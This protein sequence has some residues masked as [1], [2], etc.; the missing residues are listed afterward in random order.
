[1]NIVHCR[2]P[3]IQRQLFLVCPIQTPA[4]ISDVSTPVVLKMLLT[5]LCSASVSGCDSCMPVCSLA[6]WFQASNLC[7]CDG[8]L[9]VKIDVA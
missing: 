6:Q 1:M 5:T 8:I 3:L 4:P 9:C 7:V 2:L